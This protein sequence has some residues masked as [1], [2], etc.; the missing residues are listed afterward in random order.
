MMSINMLSLKCAKIRQ[1][2]YLNFY[3]ATHIK[4]EFIFKTAL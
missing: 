3:R 1:A 2:V 4:D